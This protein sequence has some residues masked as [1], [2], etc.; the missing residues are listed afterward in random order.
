MRRFGV[1]VLLVLLTACSTGKGSKTKAPST[2]SSTTHS[3][4]SYTDACLIYAQNPEWL[5]ASLQSSR[6]WQVPIFIF[7][8][9]I[10]QESSF[11]PEARPRASNGT[12]LSSAYGYAQA[13]DGTWRDY[14]KQS[15]NANG[16]RNQFDDAV[17]FIGWYVW[18]TYKAAG[19]SKWDA[20][21]LYLSYH[22]GIGGYL[23]RN[24]NKKP[25]LLKVAKKVGSRAT[26]YHKQLNDCG[27]PLYLE[28]GGEPPKT[29]ANKSKQPAP[30]STPK[31]A[32]ET[33]PKPVDKPRPKPPQRK[34]IRWF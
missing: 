19:V 28:K 15:G 32:S 26:R 18:R 2:S 17:D 3:R 10:Y 13:L 9:F 1:V 27:I 8:A 4:S 24:H 34:T 16:R 31:S 21:N 12:L 7:L 22:E 29:T 20:A 23:R 30:P 5:D 6:R 33:S 11:N 14:Q 25:W